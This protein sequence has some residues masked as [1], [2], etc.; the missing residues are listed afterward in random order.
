MNNR[1]LVQ[2]VVL[3]G[4]A[5]ISFIA[6]KVEPEPEVVGLLEFHVDLGQGSLFSEPISAWG[7]A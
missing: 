5:G 6:E 1:S 2:G 4:Y 3:V 7:S